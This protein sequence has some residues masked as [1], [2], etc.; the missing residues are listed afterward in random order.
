[1]KVTVNGVE[2]SF[3]LNSFAPTYTY[4]VIMGEP[5]SGATTRNIHVMMFATLLASNPDEWKMTLAQF[6][7]WLYDHPAEEQTMASAISDEFIRR[8]ELSLKKKKE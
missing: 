2:Y 8:A 5:F 7:E 1:M 3:A 4:E 6:T